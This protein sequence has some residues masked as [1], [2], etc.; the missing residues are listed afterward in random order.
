VRQTSNAGAVKKKK[1]LQ[2]SKSAR[3]GRP[4]ESKRRQLDTPSYMR[5]GEEGSGGCEKKK[6]GHVCSP[7]N[8][9]KL[10]VLKEAPVYYKDKNLWGTKK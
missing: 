4:G 2:R 8:G 5:P 10:P 3:P 9:K 7:A 1:A 6:R